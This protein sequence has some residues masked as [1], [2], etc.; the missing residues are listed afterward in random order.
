MFNSQLWVGN[1]GIMYFKNE[2]DFWNPHVENDKNLEFHRSNL[3]ISKITRTSHSF[4]SNTKMYLWTQVTS[5]GSNRVTL[6]LNKSRNNEYFD[7][8][9]F[10][11]YS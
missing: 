9:Y 8:L 11:K 2:Y 10:A 4:N 7:I 3:F 1:D 5:Y 6:D